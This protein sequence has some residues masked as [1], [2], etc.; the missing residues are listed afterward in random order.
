M[1]ICNKSD[2]FPSYKF[3]CEKCDFRTNNNSHYRKH[4]HTIKHNTTNT[5]TNTTKKRVKSYNCKICVFNSNNKTHYKKHLQTKKHKYNNTI[6][7]PSKMDKDYNNKFSCECGKTYLHRSSLYNLKKNCNI[8]N[9]KN[10][11]IN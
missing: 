9:S 7:E 10:N 8:F 3:I 2:F 5:I 1:N 11:N 6:G 4:L